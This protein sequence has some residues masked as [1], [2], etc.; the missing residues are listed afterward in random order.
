MYYLQEISW[1]PFG[2]PDKS[3]K[4]STLWVGSGGAHT[5][6]HQDTYGTNIVVQLHGK[7]VLF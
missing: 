3:G 7:Y 6:A 4:D 1:K 5:P 2:Y